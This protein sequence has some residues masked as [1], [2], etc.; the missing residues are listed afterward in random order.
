MKPSRYHQDGPAYVRAFLFR[1]G[2]LNVRA[3]SVER[4]GTALFPFPSRFCLHL[5]LLVLRAVKRCAQALYAIIKHKII[6]PRF[7]PK[8]SFLARRSR[9][10]HIIDRS[11]LR[12]APVDIVTTV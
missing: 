9:Y 7:P 3:V 5:L 1:K 2:A 8:E 4:R 12:A 6:R 11:R 10:T